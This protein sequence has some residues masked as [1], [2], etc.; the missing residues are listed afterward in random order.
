MLASTH[1]PERARHVSH[2]KLI[3]YRQREAAAAE[4]GVVWHKIVVNVGTFPRDTTIHT[5]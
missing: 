3:R 1:P 4:T 5:L 2:I